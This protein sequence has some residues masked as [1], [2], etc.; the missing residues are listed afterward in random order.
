M[1]QTSKFTFIRNA[2]HVIL[3]KWI[4]SLNIDFIFFSFCY[5]ILIVV[6]IDSFFL[7]KKKSMIMNP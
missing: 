4:N 3:D 2:K 1:M 6:S 7:L 5:F